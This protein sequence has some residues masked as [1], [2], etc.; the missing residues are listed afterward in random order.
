MPQELALYGDLT[1][2][3]TMF[4]FGILHRMSRRR[5]KDRGDFLLG[6]LELPSQSRLIRKLSGGQQR[7][8]SF[9]VAMLQ[10]PPLLI[11]DEPTVGVDPLLRAKI[12]QHLTELVSS[13]QTTIILTTH[14]IEEAR[15]ANVVGL[16]RD[17]QLLAESD[18]NALINFYRMRAL[19]DVFLHLCRR[20]DGQNMTS[21]A[22]INSPTST[23]TSEEE[24]PLLME[25]RARRQKSSDTQST[26]REFDDVHVQTNGSRHFK[27]YIAHGCQNVLSAFSC[28]LATCCPRPTNI[29][30]LFW[31]NAAKIYRNPL[32]VI[33]QFLIPTLQVSLLCLTIGRNLH[34]VNLAYVNADTGGNTSD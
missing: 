16:M 10:E 7:R 5:M 4:Y 9:A 33:F 29:L 6:L 13:T 2:M 21:P 12:W 23:L 8:V 3:E 24:T 11:L 15:Q 17:G 19:E 34:G 18:P 30:A 25:D 32:V 27:K 1:M 28:N 14:Y 22:S 31:K 20:Q 26:D